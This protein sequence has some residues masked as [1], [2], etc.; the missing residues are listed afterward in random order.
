MNKSSL[1]HILKKELREMFRDKKSLSM[2][3]VIPLMIPLLIIGMSYLFNSE[4]NKDVEEY[5]NIGF[6][7]SL[8]EAEKNLAK[9]MKIK[10]HEESEKQLK[11]KYENEKLDLY[12]TKENN[13]YTMHGNDSERTS[14]A[15]VLMEEYFT[16]Y[17][18]YLQNVNLTN[19]GVEAE[20][21]LNPITI[22]QDIT[23]EDNFFANYITTYS[24][25]FIIMA[26]TVSATYP[27][28][29]ATAGEKERGTLET[30]LTFPVK[31]KDIILG[32]FFGVTISSVIT[33]LLSLILTVI[34]LGIAND[35]FELYDGIDLMLSPTSLV[36]TTI[37]VVAYS[38]LISGLC[39]AIASKA[40]SFKEAQSSLTPLT[41]ITFFPGMIAMLV[42][43]KTTNLLALIPFLNY[44]LLFEDITKGDFNII[45]IIL[46]A[47]STVV[48]IW[49]VLKIIIKQYK[50]EKVL[51]SI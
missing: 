38:I 21:V 2:M 31:S 27:A 41:F 4:V 29:D 36:F 42:N 14:Y 6:A 40:K 17:K 47:I 34:S 33:G 18:E 46:M 25:L 1:I 50:S 51:F 12:I 22:K 49:I 26:I 45:H 15:L 20:K 44:T 23:K 9:E 32:K 7:Y 39:I 16:Y 37:I 10:I 5:N 43:I 13:T 3:L 35:M 8:T 48:I 19:I 11:D 24:F 30:L 28:T